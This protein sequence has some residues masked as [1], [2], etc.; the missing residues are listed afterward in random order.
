MG[1]LNCTPD[2][3]SDG[4]QFVT[5][6]A[7]LSHV[8]KMINEGAGIIDIGGMSSR[9]GA[10]IISAD[11]ELERVERHIE[12]IRREF[13]ETILSI[14]T[15]HSRVAKAA[16][17]KGVSIINDISFGTI[18]EKLPLL[19]VEYNTP[20]IGMHMKGIPINM[21][22]N[23]IYDQGV[24]LDIIQYLTVRSRKIESLGVKDIIIDPGFGFGKTIHQNYALLNSLE[25][26]SILNRP[27]LVGLSR[28]SMIW[29]LLK[30]TPK[31]TLNA[32]SA[33]HLQALL[34][35]ANIIRAHDVSPVKQII[36][37]FR[38]LSS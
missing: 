36:Q 19:A 17:E 13:P 25:T 29:K 33:L 14:D 26:F 24:V 8:E 3:F 27:I 10:K 4:G 11:E 23:T 18:D 9:P 1:I 30:T 7:A 28:K 2:S 35:G 20:Y 12:N 32:T 38:E 31:N 22:N 16:I 21:Q 5:E 6:K 34:K 37:L 15:V